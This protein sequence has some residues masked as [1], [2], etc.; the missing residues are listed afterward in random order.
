[1]VRLQSPPTL[2]LIIIIIMVCLCRG[3]Y[4]DTCLEIVLLIYYFIQK[5]YLTTSKYSNIGYK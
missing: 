5:Y 3:I 2:S 4:I 1:M